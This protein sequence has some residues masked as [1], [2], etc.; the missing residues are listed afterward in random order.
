MNQS[1]TSGPHRSVLEELDE[2][3][4]A[5]SLL[6]LDAL[7]DGSNGV[8][9]DLFFYGVISVSSMAIRS[10]RSHVPCHA[11]VRAS[12][13]V[14]SMRSKPIRLRFPK[15]AVFGRRINPLQQFPVLLAA[16]FFNIVRPKRLPARKPLGQQARR[17]WLPRVSAE[18][19]EFLLLARQLQDE[20]NIFLVAALEDRGDDMAR[21]RVNLMLKLSVISLAKE[22]VHTDGVLVPRFRVSSAW[23]ESDVSNRIAYLSISQHHIDIAYPFCLFGIKDSESGRNRSDAIPVAHPAELTLWNIGEAK[24]LIAVFRLKERDVSGFTALF[25]NGDAI[26][27][28]LIKR[29]VNLHIP[30][31]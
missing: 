9:I 24:R 21:Q 22:T 10:G 28:L 5:N 12:D 27:K 1:V 6:S 31:R 8:G 4:V 19:H 29:P 3:I 15:R 25:E 18:N 23:P 7:D 30:R 11:P 20:G 2:L 26:A 16:Y 17:K 13:R 14:L